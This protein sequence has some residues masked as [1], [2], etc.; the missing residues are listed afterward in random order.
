MLNGQSYLLDPAFKLVGSL[1]STMASSSSDQVNHPQFPPHFSVIWFFK[2][3]TWFLAKQLCSLI[4]QSFDAWRLMRFWS[5]AQRQF[6]LQRQTLPELPLVLQNAL[7]R[8]KQYL[9]QSESVKPAQ[10][11][12]EL[13]EVAGNR[14]PLELKKLLCCLVEEE[15]RDERL[16]EERNLLLKVEAELAKE[17]AQA[18]QRILAHLNAFTDQFSISRKVILVGPGEQRMI[19]DL[20]AYVHS[21]KRSRV[22]I[23]F[24]LRHRLPEGVLP[25]AS[26]GGGAERL[27][28]ASAGSA[29][30]RGHRR[31]LE[32]V[33]G[34]EA[35]AC[36]VPGDMLFVA[37]KAH[38]A[39]LLGRLAG[40]RGRPG[41]AGEKE[42]GE[43]GVPD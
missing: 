23:D 5:S 10:V 13:L 14:F 38:H 32:H 40:V 36:A 18:N 37:G 42:A 27:A 4:G 11:I 21:R 2:M 25:D 41:A 33:G 24:I 3:D 8:V 34:A 30:E 7:L 15:F 22:E 6:E 20:A 26:P 12:R 29:K 1:S 17:F 43:R 19:L 9:L 16:S 28:A 39:V 31:R 35:A